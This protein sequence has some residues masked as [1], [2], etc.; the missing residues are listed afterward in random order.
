MLLPGVAL[1]AASAALICTSVVALGHLRYPPALDLAGPRTGTA[2]LT[3]T[4]TV[5]ETDAPTFGAPG[6]A[7]AGGG[8]AGSVSL[9]VRVMVEASLEGFSFGGRSVSARSPTLVFATLETA[10][11]GSAGGGLAIGARVSARGTLTPVEAGESREFLFFARGELEVVGDPP[12][13]VAWAHG[14]RDA[15][16]E[17]TSELPGDG[18]DLLTG[19]AIGDDT[20]VTDD[21]RDAMTVTGLTHL[22]AVSGANCAIVVAAVMLVGGALGLRRRV[23]VAVAILV[24]LL[25]VVL[26]TPEPSVLRAATMAVIVLVALALGRPAAGIPPLCLSVVVLLAL[27][28][29]LARSAGFALSV[30]A[31]AGLLLLTRPLTA[32][33]SR[34]VPPVLAVAIAVPVAAQLACQP[35]LFLL[36][37]QLTPY[38]VPA[39]LLAEPAAAAVSVLGLIVCV[40]A[41]VAPGVAEVAAWLPWLPSAWIGAVARFFAAAP[42]AAIDLPDSVLASAGAV[43]MLVLLGVA[44]HRRRTQPRVARAAAL[45]MVLSAVVVAGA[46]AGGAV[47]RNGAVPPDWQ[48]AACD[49]GQGD[50]VLV[51]SAGLTALIDVGPDPE[52]LAACLQDLAIE[53]LDL[54]VL[55]H[56]DLDH[57]GGLDAVLGRVD[58]ALVGP[59]DGPPDERLLDTLRTHGAEVV[60]A[61]RGLTGTL[62]RYR[63][64]VLWPPDPAGRATPLVGNDA[65]IIM[66]FSGPLRMLFLGDLGELAQSALDSTATP[67]EVDVVKV[68]HHG[69]ADQSDALYLVLRAR[70]GIISVGADNTYGHPTDR[71]LALLA[72][73]GTEAFR[74]DTGGLIALAGTSAHLTVW[75]ENPPTRAPP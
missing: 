17:A 22:T 53:R 56:Y 36:A 19:L 7:G 59:T 75:T 49:I 18:A 51:R 11:P 26:V 47:G 62:G 30:L 71:L 8:G 12:W 54:L 43:L 9:P 41:V 70:V 74:T 20:E 34:W 31:T 37:P 27:D 55:T 58:R 50:A 32:L 46:L 3:I 64:D 39:N 1:A 4:G 28:P 40:L 61:S 29:W 42:F 24:L 6:G 60:Q 16:R 72:R 5:D 33:V 14:M 45:A 69:S 38:T 44:L 66:E 21:L 52:P 2:I 68:A 67:T 63:F 13:S 25:F 15:F 10:V 35:I 23:R 73:A 65:S 48:L 57:V